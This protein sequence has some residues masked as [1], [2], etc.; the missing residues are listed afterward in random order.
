MRK[1]VNKVRYIYIFL[2]LRDEVRRKRPEKRRTNSWF[3]LHDNAPAH[4]SVFV[5]DFLAKNNVTI[6]QHQPHSPDLAPVDFY[7]FLRLKSASKGRRFCDGA[8]IIKNATEE[9]K[10]LSQ[11]GFQ[12]CFQHLYIRSQKCVLAQV[13]YF[14]GSLNDCTICVSKK[15]IITGAF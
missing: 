1:T 14:E 15:E 7:Q 2:R 6:L 12:E 8:D 10:K 13:D 4:W 5:K 3:L 9:L 11:N